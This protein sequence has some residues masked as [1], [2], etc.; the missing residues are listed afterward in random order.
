MVGQ[1]NIRAL[2]LLKHLRAF[3]FF[4]FFSFWLKLTSQSKLHSVPVVIESWCPYG[5]LV[6]RRL[7]RFV[8]VSL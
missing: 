6:P 1:P 4:L 5:V 3:S 2:A 7:I 8:R